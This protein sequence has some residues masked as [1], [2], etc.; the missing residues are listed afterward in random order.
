MIVDTHCHE[1]AFDP[2][3]IGLHRA[4]QLVEQQLRAGVTHG[5]LSILN[6]DD[7]AKGNS[8]TFEVTQAYPGHMYGHIYLN[9][10]DVPA[11]L[12]EIDRCVELGNFRGA[13]LHPSE[14]AW[15]PYFE[16][17]YPVYERLES[18]GYPILF[19]SGTYPHSG[20]LSIAYA[21][22]D[23]PKTPFILG[24]FGLAD[25]SWECFPAASLSENVYVDTT[26]NPM[27]RV[28]REW[29]DTF[30]AHRMLWGSD[31]PFY[32]V[33]YELDKLS[34]LELNDEERALIEHGNATRIYGLDVAPGVPV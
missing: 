2:L 4:D 26:A 25:S 9:V 27:V 8:R 12:D 34:A 6:R 32:N 23:F 15:F 33:Q 18:L 3:F 11:C 29:L 28:M 24:H 19:H 17:Y 14:D 21:A 7:M 10:H 16:K 5:L 22:R 20:P 13:K 31:F 1:G 30:G